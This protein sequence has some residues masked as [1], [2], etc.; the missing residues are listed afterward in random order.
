MIT[1]LA[2]SAVALGGVARASVIQLSVAELKV[3]AIELQRQIDQ[4]T[5]QQARVL[6]EADQRQAW[7]GTGARNAA[8]WLAGATKSSYGSAKRKQ[9]LGEALS[10]SP[11]LS[12][13]VDNGEVTPDAA[14][15]LAD[16]V[17]NPPAGADP[18]EL[19]EACKGASPTEA[20][21][22]ARR[23]K[24]VHSEETPEQ[25][26][27]RRYQ[28]RSLRHTEEV[29]GQ[30]TIN[31]T[32]PTLQA[33]Q[34]LKVCSFLGGKPSQTDTRSTA[35]RMCDGLILLA[36]AYAKGEV[37]GGREKPTLLITFSADSFEGSSDEPGVTDFG[38]RIPAHI[39][40]RLAEHAQLQRVLSTGSH[41]LDLGRTERY[42]TEQQ[43]RALMALH[44]GCDWEGCHIPAAWCEVDHL[45]PWEE[46]GATDL[47]NLGLLCS[48]H[49]HEKHRP[50][51]VVTGDASGYTIT[52]VDGTVVRCGPRG[53]TAQAAA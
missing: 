33:R 18:G 3:A 46:G 30:I 23:W 36:D 40:R 41:I 53:R 21:D 50:G 15:E 1:A 39:V 27:E 20:R 14:N 45:V 5:V 29:D 10:Q 22:A 26:E 11:D 34:V 12:A 48:H 19:V 8:D 6:S 49:H 28:N 9:Q 24:E 32:L 37:R 25:A 44:G 47:D 42:A 35:Q 51:V 4:L 17:L 38:D 52:L 2:T 16:A 13:A 7:Q 31:A 43:Y